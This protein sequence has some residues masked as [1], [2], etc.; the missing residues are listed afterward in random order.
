ME[1]TR[2]S[3]LLQRQT[4]VVEFLATNSFLWTLQRK[5]S[6]WKEILNNSAKNITTKCSKFPKY[7]GKYPSGSASWIASPSQGWDQKHRKMD[8]F[9]ER[10]LGPGAAREDATASC[11]G[12]RRGTAA[13]RAAAA[14]AVLPWPRHS[15]AP[16]CSSV[17]LPHPRG[18]Q[19]GG[20]CVSSLAWQT[21]VQCHLWDALPLLQR[22]PGA[23][24]SCIGMGESWSPAGGSL[25]VE[26]LA[27]A[28]RLKTCC[29][30][31]WQ[32]EDFLGSPLK[33][34]VSCNTVC[35]FSIC[36][37]GKKNPN[38]QPCWVIK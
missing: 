23:S 2:G 8:P 13:E 21:F 34:K 7:D 38:T 18:W 28:C 37:F 6:L 36:F 3:S 24:G 17:C 9:Q 4:Y 29:C 10:L 25:L 32:G 33:K 31:W 27:P 26:A 19:V 30:V 16:G 14:P 5:V 15:S 12:F 35:G 11:C 1:G 20:T 22:W